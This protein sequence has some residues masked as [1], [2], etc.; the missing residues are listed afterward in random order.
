[1][2]E[3]QKLVDDYVRVC[4][5]RGLSPVTVE[6]RQRELDRWGQWLRKRDPR[7]NVRDIGQ[8]LIVDYVKSRSAFAART[9]VGGIMSE[10]RCMGEYLVSQGV[11]GQNPLRWMR[12]PKLDPR[13]RLPAGIE[14]VHLRA[15]FAEIENVR[16]SYHRQLMLTTLLLFYGI[17]IRRGELMRLNVSDWDSRTGTLRIENT[18]SNR[19][20]HIPLPPIVAAGIEAYLPYRTT[21]LARLNKLDETALFLNRSG[22]RL[23]GDRYGALL[24]RV[25]K[26]ANIPL[27]SVHQFRHTCASDLLRN[28]VGI[29]EIQKILDH[30]CLQTTYRY[31]HVADPSRR[32]AIQ[33]HPINLILK[34]TQTIEGAV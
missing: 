5:L 23:N 28:G 30:A 3:W 12:G 21:L 8:D 32:E 27:V 17:G 20:R 18:K 22:I 31:S 13:R 2:N 19:E 10:L 33:K 25:A 4:R 11:W 1:M 29:A 6:L 24:H 9:T 34:G 7:F 16:Q 15:L 14:K 26:K